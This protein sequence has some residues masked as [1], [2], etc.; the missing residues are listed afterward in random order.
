MRQKNTKSLLQKSQQYYDC[1]EFMRLTMGLGVM[2]Q[3]SH[4]AKNMAVTAHSANYL[5]QG[6][7]DPINI[8]M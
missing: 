6:T 1:T 4:H 5:F 8:K 7:H 3:S 2:V